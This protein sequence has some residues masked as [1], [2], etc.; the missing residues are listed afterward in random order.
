MWAPSLHR[1]CRK[2]GFIHK[3]NRKCKLFPLFNQGND[4]S[5]PR[6][7]L[8]VKLLACRLLSAKSIRIR[9]S[10]FSLTSSS[11]PSTLWSRAILKLL[12]VLSGWN[13]PR[14]PYIYKGSPVSVDNLGPY[15]VRL[16]MLLW[17]S[18]L[19]WSDFIIISRLFVL[20]NK[21]VLFFNLKWFYDS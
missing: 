17:I 9:C 3:S 8:H 16:S 11:I 18:A 2:S 4:D 6:Y 5:T 10:L 19:C 20:I 1:P 12:S 15:L 21:A 14:C 7:P 13:P